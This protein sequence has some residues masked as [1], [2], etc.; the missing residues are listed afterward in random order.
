MLLHGL[1]NEEIDRLL[2]PVILAE[3]EGC[4]KVLHVMAETENEVG[5]IF[6]AGLLDAA[7]ALI[8][9]RRNSGER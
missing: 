6:N 7:A 5:E 4:A 9:E 1:T 3:R 8:S 2:A